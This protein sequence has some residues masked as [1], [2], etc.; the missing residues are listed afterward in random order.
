MEISRIT[1][2][3]SSSPRDGNRL[4]AVACLGDHHQ[5]GFVLQERSQTPPDNGMIVGDQ[6]STGPH[7]GIDPHRFP[8]YAIG[9]HRVN[10]LT[11]VFS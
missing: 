8:C 6:N 2:W 9:F 3:G 10:T 11:V 4:P 7:G 5:A 1:T